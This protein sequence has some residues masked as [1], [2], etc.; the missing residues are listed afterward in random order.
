MNMLEVI[1]CDHIGVK[2]FFATGGTAQALNSLITHNVVCTRTALYRN[3]CVVPGRWLTTVQSIFSI[4]W[5]V[6]VV[7]VTGF[8]RL[9]SVI[10]HLETIRS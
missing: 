9:C 2:L 5:Q 4:G 1:Y 10:S 3:N 7:L 8:C 6:L